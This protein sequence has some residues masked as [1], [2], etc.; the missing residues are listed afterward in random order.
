MAML[1]D[2]KKFALK[3]NV[4]DLAVGVI[5]GAAFGK[6]VTALIENIIMP[7]VGLAIPGGDWRNGGFVVRHGA[8]PAQD[9]IVKW[10]AFAGA[11][12]DFLVIAFVLF[13][14]VSKVV[15]AFERKK[16]EAP[17]TKECPQ[18]LEEIAI[19]AHRCKYCTSQV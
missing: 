18:C 5:I 14:L 9:V 8:T 16:P 13:I 2:F 4:V 7:V 1:T 19:K 17:T 3:G 12:I 10:G 6:I 15:K 11:V